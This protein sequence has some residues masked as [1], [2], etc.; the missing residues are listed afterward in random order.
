[1]EK[2]NI[3]EVKFED[4]E[5]EKFGI[6]AISDVES[7]AI[8]SLFIAL[9]K[10]KKEEMAVKLMDEDKK[11]LIGLALIPNKPILRRTENGEEFYIIFSKD[12]IRHAS[13]L[14]LKRNNQNNTTLEH[15]D[16][17]IE[18][19]T[20]VES[21]IV[22][23]TEKDK[24][25][26]YGLSAPVGSWAVVKKVYNDDYWNDE[27]KTGNVKG[28]SIEGVFMPELR[29]DLSKVELSDDDKIKEVKKLL[30]IE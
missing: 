8:D 30:N 1:M 25:A 10:E 11:L 16:K 18:G 17:L 28:F 9:S 7:P 22:E 19:V 26:L 27:V 15:S 14:Y 29:E 6:H 24:T 21:W 20:T 3:Y 23:D 12:T 2:K 5:D 13:Q 4:L